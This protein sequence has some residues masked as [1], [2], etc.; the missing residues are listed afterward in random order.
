[1]IPML[2]FRREGR[3]RFRIRLSRSETRVGRGARCD[4]TLPEDHISRVHFLVRRSG[5]RYR[6]L[7]RS[8]NGTLLNGER[9]DE[10]GLGVGDVIR[11]PPWEVG[12]IEGNGVEPQETAVRDLLNP[13]PVVSTTLDGTRLLVRAG[14]MRVCDGPAEGERYVI[15]KPEVRVGS[16]PSCD[17]VLAGDVAPVHFH[18][19]MERGRYRLHDAGTADGTRVDGADVQ[20]PVDLCEGARV[21]AGGTTIELLSRTHEDPL[22]PMDTDR[23]IDLV[24]ASRPMRELYQMIRRVAPARVPALILGESGSGKELVARALHRIGPRSGGPFV[25]VNCGALPSELVESELFGHVKGA[26]TG[27]TSHRLGAFREANGGVLFLDEIGDLAP[28]AQV[29]LLRALENG[30]VRPVG[31]DREEAVD[32]RVVAATHRDLAAEIDGGR[33]REDLFFRLC[34]GMVHVPPLRSRR[35]DIPLLARHLLSTAVP[36]RELRISAAA[37]AELKDHGWR[38]NVRALRN[39]LLRASL[40]ADGDAIEPAHLRFDLTPGNGSD[41]LMG[42]N[43]QELVGSLERAERQAIQNALDACGGNKMA[44]AKVLGIAKSTLHAKL[45]RY[46]L[47]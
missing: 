40:L 4:V 18:V 2:E 33:F 45:K 1:M 21:E 19:R 30:V 46:G 24:G 25:A 44:A 26:F 39:V 41:P 36:E 8:R 23:F 12:L 11:L 43:R 3:P 22:R 6:L 29:R 13:A 35:E 38:G 42:M 16:D 17:W 37:M 9:I 32:V 14:E 7:D 15:R 28:A 20:G 10:S 31:A 34:V 47:G 5:E 27:A